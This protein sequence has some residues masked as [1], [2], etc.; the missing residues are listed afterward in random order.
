MF[1]DGLSHVLLCVAAI[2]QQAQHA[3]VPV[4]TA[5]YMTDRDAKLGEDEMI[6][7]INKA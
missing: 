4:V 5:P 3:T 1:L 7:V 2:A 6:E